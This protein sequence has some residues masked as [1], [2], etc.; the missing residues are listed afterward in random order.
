M[1]FDAAPRRSPSGRRPT[2]E[3]ARDCFRLHRVVAFAVVLA[4]LAGCG[5]RTGLTL[6]REAPVDAAAPCEDECCA[7]FIELPPTLTRRGARAF[8]RGDSL[9]L[10]S[11]ASDRLEVS[12]YTLDGLARG[13]VDSIAT[14]ETLDLDVGQSFA[15]AEHEPLAVVV[16]RPSRLVVELPTVSPSVRGLGRLDSF[17]DGLPRS[18]YGVAG[19]SEIAFYRSGGS[20]LIFSRATSEEGGW[21]TE[22]LDAGAD[23]WPFGSCDHPPVYLGDAGWAAACIV[24]DA[25]G[26][27]L[28]RLHLRRDGVV[29]R[30]DD[31]L[32][33]AF[34]LR[35]RDI[36]GLTQ[37]S[38]AAEDRTSL[39][40]ITNGWRRDADDQY[41]LGVRRSA[42]GEL[43]VEEIAAV[44]DGSLIDGVSAAISEG[45]TAVC[46]VGRATVVTLHCRV[47]SP[48]RDPRQLARTLDGVGGQRVQP[49]AMLSES[50]LAVE[51][52]YVDDE[53]GEPTIGVASWCL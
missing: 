41:L 30:D 50:H 27:T 42:T 36:V 15:N 38:L 18:G 11:V 16:T 47:S 12:R 44:E 25:S 8:L 7:R 37:F 43:D 3:P 13:E 51:L 32:G 49:R 17:A 6:D 1:A 26:A 19:R 9:L 24:G 29:T 46:W 52:A 34:G 5:G 45:M 14:P 21:R 31:D 4:G 53:A 23:P 33:A 39:L 10:A 35:N 40:V 28:H 20:G 48:D 2:S 22:E